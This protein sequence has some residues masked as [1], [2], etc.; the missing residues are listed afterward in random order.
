MAEWY[1][2]LDGKTVGPFEAQVIRQMLADGSLTFDDY[3]WD[4]DTESWKVLREN[5][6]L[7]VDIPDQ[8][9][10]HPEQCPDEIFPPAV[11]DITRTYE[12]CAIHP[13]KPLQFVC[14]SCHKPHCLECLQ[15]D[16]GLY[17]CSVCHSS[18]KKVVTSRVSETGKSPLKDFLL[19]NSLVW[20]LVL[21][22]IPL[23]GFKV[24]HEIYNP[25]K[26]FPEYYP[27]LKQAAFL[28]KTES[29]LQDP[30]YSE[31]VDIYRKISLE[32]SKKAY[33]LDNTILPSYL[34]Y[35]ISCERLERWEDGLKTVKNQDI[36]RSG[37]D[38]EQGKKLAYLES[39]FLAR[40]GELQMLAERME[41]LQPRISNN[42]T[43]GF[44]FRPPPMNVPVS[45]LFRGGKK[46][47]MDLK[48]EA[49]SLIWY[50]EKKL[51]SAVAGIAFE[52]LLRSKTSEQA[53]EPVR[54][55]LSPEEIAAQDRMRF[56]E[57]LNGLKKRVSLLR[58]ENTQQRKLLPDALA[59]GSK[60]NERDVLDALIDA[61]K[62]KGIQ[63]LSSSGDKRKNYREKFPTIFVNL[64]GKVKRF[65]SLVSYLDQ[66]TKPTNFPF[67]CAIY[68]VNGSVS[69]DGTWT[70]RMSL[71]VPL[72]SPHLSGSTD[73]PEVGVVP[74]D[75][76][77][78][79]LEKQERKLS[80]II[81]LLEQQKPEL[82]EL[83][84]WLDRFF[85][86]T[87]P[88]LSVLGQQHT[89]PQ[90]TR[91]DLSQRYLRVSLE[92]PKSVSVESLV[93]KLRRFSRTF[94]LK[95]D[96][97]EQSYRDKSLTEISFEY[98]NRNR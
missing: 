71:H 59:S 12:S 74:V 1:L 61:A 42:G 36:P 24:L 62:K 28:L 3:F 20:S 60:W 66:I 9:P 55:K 63:I 48:R 39:L 58:E 94:H 52:N 82:E 15:Y 83:R 40:G 35:L 91:F 67:S 30:K 51:M 27:Y 45:P 32:S 75:A 2:Y 93:K 80:S 53:P 54:P 57:A 64:S 70:V 19:K 81:R 72:V 41:V 5:P 31:L 92:A 65:R 29:V 7:V 43:R 17:I 97:R 88:M 25:F 16:A 95:E 6:D 90:V 18:G 56:I 85:P 68:A 77:M 78:E 26:G 96:I 79:E 34:F 14:E 13:D 98:N 89:G 86:A 33:D 22:L 10:R 49:F 87:V 73:L 44:M 11:L 37:L 76:P 69:R 38:Q 50:D 8:T 21:I 84:K 4:P 46:Y 23:L 47:D